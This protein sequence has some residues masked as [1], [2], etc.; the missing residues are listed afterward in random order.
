MRVD[1]SVSCAM[2]PHWVM[3]G[4][5]RF[6]PFWLRFERRRYCLVARCC[7]TPV[8]CWPRHLSHL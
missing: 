6:P 1:D 3:L 2:I 8:Q 4:Y 7:L 5:V